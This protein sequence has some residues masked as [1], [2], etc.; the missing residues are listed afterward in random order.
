[1]ACTSAWMIC[2]PT[3]DDIIRRLWDL[4]E[5]EASYALIEGPFGNLTEASLEVIGWRAPLS[6]RELRRRN[7]QVYGD[8][9]YLATRR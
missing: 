9:A 2:R 3:T 6:T 8:P 7:G 5:Q 1:M 4:N